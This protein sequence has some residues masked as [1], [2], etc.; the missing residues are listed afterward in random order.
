LFVSGVVTTV[1]VLVI[2]WHVWAVWTAVTN[3]IGNLYPVLLQ[4]YTR[5][6]L[7]RLPRLRR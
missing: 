2:G 3:V 4:R 1:Y 6:R 7:V 5:A